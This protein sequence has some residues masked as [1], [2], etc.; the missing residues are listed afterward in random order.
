[1]ES[2]LNPV[3]AK[4]ENQWKQ[5]GQKGQKRQ[6]LFVFF[7]LFALFASIN[8]TSVTLNVFLASCS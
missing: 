1:V 5:K 6:N 7:A 3:R 8:L 2:A 4:L